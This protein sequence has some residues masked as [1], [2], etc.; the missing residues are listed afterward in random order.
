[1]DGA[2]GPKVRGWAVTR[3]IASPRWS[4]SFRGKRAGVIAVPA[5]LIAVGLGLRLGFALVATPHGDEYIQIWAARAVGGRGLPIIGQDLFY[6]HGL[7][8][9]YLIA[10]VVKI[11]PE[12]LAP[13]LVSVAVSTLGLAVAFV[14]L[15]RLLDPFGALAALAFLAVEPTAVEWGSR[16]RMYS[17]VLTVSTVLILISL[18]L[19]LD[20]WSRRR[21]ALLVGAYALAVVT[22]ALVE[23]L[24]PAIGLILLTGAYH[25]RISFARAGLAAAP[26]FALAVGAHLARLWTRFSGEGVAGLPA[27]FEPL[28]PAQGLLKFA[29]LWLPYFTQPERLP[30][31]L[32]IAVGL[33]VGVRRLVS[34][35]GRGGKSVSTYAALPLLA[36]VASFSMLLISRWAAYRYLLIAWPLLAAF[37]GCGASYLVSLSEYRRILAKPAIAGA[38]TLTLAAVAAAGWTSRPPE[39]PDFDGAFTYLRS[40]AD[41]SDSVLSTHPVALRLELGRPGYFF[42]AKPAAAAYL[43]TDEEGGVYDVW[44]AQPWIG[45]I[46]T[47]RQT[48]DKPGRT[49]IVLTERGRDSFD[50]EMRAYLQSNFNTVQRFAG[51]DILMHQTTAL[52]E[53]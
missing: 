43:R 15:K 21:L 10:P 38:L 24:A 14:L 18:L 3:A 32:L 34:R 26:V 53:P 33:G 5:V 12:I 16:A 2:R 30:F 20:G 36:L 48:I 23:L 51:L 40:T 13:R 50:A 1:M 8:Y 42:F 17:L 47:L 28:A 35:R 37:V 19:V 31:A 39:L 6:A 46:A 25:R 29:S 27:D 11:A 52:R 49:W 9:T 4:L 22:H 44:T 45:T 41:T 7:P